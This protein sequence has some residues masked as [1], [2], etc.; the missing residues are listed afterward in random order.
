MRKYYEGKLLVPI[1]VDIGDHKLVTISFCQTSQFR[2]LETSDY[3][4]PSQIDLGKISAIQAK[5]NFRPIHR[6][7]SQPCGADAEFVWRSV[8]AECSTLSAHSNC[9]TSSQQLW[10]RAPGW[11]ISSWPGHLLVDDLLVLLGT[12]AEHLDQ[13]VNGSGG[14]EGANDPPSLLGTIHSFTVLQSHSHNLWVSVWSKAIF[15][16]T[17]S[18]IVQLTCILACCPFFCPSL[19][20]TDSTRVQTLKTEPSKVEI[21]K[22]FH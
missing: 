5:C 8:W 18:I 16:M 9:Q 17:R 7:D 20:R 13:L 2:F 6:P 14:N 12:R 1:P 19:V 15:R 11:M 3:Q 21:L 10:A 4:T 22:T